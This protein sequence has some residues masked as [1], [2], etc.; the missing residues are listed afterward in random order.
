MKVPKVHNGKRAL[1]VLVMLRIGHL[2]IFATFAVFGSPFVG[3]IMILLAFVY[4][5]AL[6]GILAESSLGV[7]C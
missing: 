1:L 2:S 4:F 3:I 6:F 5:F 7:I